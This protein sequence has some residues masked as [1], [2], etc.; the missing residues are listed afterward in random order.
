MQHG[1][2]IKV[3]C[4]KQDN[5]IIAYPGSIGYYA[6]CGTPIIM[7]KC[8]DEDTFMFDTKINKCR[9]NCKKA[10][11]FVDR[12]ACQRYFICERAGGV[13]IEQECPTDHRFNGKECV[14]E[15]NCVPEIKTLSFWV[16]AEQSI[17]VYMKIIK[18]DV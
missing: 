18:N 6:F 2:C 15:P 10:G 8:A 9:F 14:H 13:A 5:K 1:Q 16:E 11:Y 4:A 3:N 17:Y 7:F 12:L